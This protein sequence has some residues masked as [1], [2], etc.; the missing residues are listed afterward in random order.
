MA[1]E[2]EKTSIKV[3]GGF[4]YGQ[5]GC[6]VF[7]YTKTGEEV[8]DEARKGLG[9]KVREREGGVGTEENILN[10]CKPERVRTGLCR[11]GVT[12][13]TA[14]S[15]SKAPCGHHTW[16]RSNGRHWSQ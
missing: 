8:Q 3:H 16:A 1:A 6:Y 14:S 11:C 9:R 10:L 15:L 4:Q 13:G 7:E 2:L 12:L 5:L